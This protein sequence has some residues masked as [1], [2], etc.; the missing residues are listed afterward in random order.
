MV[1]WWLQC[2]LWPWWLWWAGY[3][4]M[5]AVGA[6]GGGDL[7]RE[8]S[9]ARGQMPGAVAIFFSL[10]V[11]HHNADYGGVLHEA[12]V[13]V[14]VGAGGA[15]APLG[16]I[17]AVAWVRVGRA[18][19]ER[20]LVW[21]RWRPARRRSRTRTQPSRPRSAARPTAARCTCRCLSRVRTPG[22]CG[23]EWGGWCRVWLQWGGVE[24]VVES[25]VHGLSGRGFGVQGSAGLSGEGRSHTWRVRRGRG[26]GVG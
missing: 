23:G 16:C 5:G 19:S 12:V 18:W 9:S 20:G 2:L 25:G 4:C 7:V 3:G 26:A 22:K 13:G 1:T 10:S 21:L 8:P 24:N 17:G 6:V 11:T 14:S 15:R